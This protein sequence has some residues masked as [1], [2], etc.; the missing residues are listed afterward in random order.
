MRGYVYHCM[1]FPL[2]WCS[3]AI[4]EGW[5]NQKLTGDQT[6]AVLAVAEEIGDTPLILNATVSSN[7]NAKTAG[8]ADILF[9]SFRYGEA[10]CFAGTARFVGSRTLSGE[11]EWALAPLSI[12]YI[13]WPARKNCDDRSIGSS[14]RLE[15]PIDVDTLAWILERSK[16]IFE[17]GV[18]QLG[19]SQKQ[20]DGRI[21]Q[22][23]RIGLQYN[24]EHGFEFVSRFSVS[25]C[26]GLSVTFR[27]QNQQI[28]VT[29][30]GHIVC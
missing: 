16:H 8:I 23:K 7:T 20:L 15:D 14:I 3:L 26:N 13:Y 9:E 12:D 21:A 2:A 4:G 18:D 30:A 1:V 25:T 19:D 29:D 28:I 6:I 10:G 11:L 24:T 5:A 27:I 17:R 22:L